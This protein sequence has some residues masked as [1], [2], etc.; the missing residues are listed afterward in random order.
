M[1][2][3]YLLPFHLETALQSCKQQYHG[4][5]VGA[6]A[7]GDQSTRLATSQ[8]LVENWCGLYWQTLLEACCKPAG[9]WVPASAAAHLP[10]ICSRSNSSICQL[11]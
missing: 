5:L 3:A 1:F 9:A 7:N 10:P 8:L 2:H 6:E 11:G 4:N